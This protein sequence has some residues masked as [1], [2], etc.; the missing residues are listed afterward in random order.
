[1][2]DTKRRFWHRK[3]NPNP[4]VTASPQLI[5]V[6][7]LFDGTAG[8]YASIYRK[9]A[10]VR[11]VV[12]FL[13]DAVSSTS[14]KV[15]NRGAK[16][17]PEARNHPYSRLLRSP[18]PEMTQKR[19]ISDVVHDL[20]LYANAYWWKME[21]GGTRWVVPIPPVRVV[22]RGG[23]L[24]S[25]SGYD[26]YGFERPEPV[27]IPREEMVHFRLYDPEDRRI[28]DSKLNA[29]RTILSEE[30]E[31]SK[32]RSGFWANAARRDGIIEMEKDAPVLSDEARKRFREDWQN[33][34]AGAMNAG[35]TV[36]LEG[37]MHWNADSFSPKDSAF[38]EGRLFVLEATARVFNVP[39]PLLGLTETATY[40][41]QK[42]F[43]KALYQDTLPPWYE[44]IQSELDLQLKPW[45]TDD[46]DIYTEFDPDSK[47]WGD[48]IERA[49]VL[50]QTIGRPYMTVEEG[51]ALENLPDR[52]DGTDAELAIPVNNIQLGSTPPPPP[53]LPAPQLQA[54]SLAVEAFRERQYRSVKSRLGAGGDFDRQRWNR[55]LTAVL[56]TQ[57][58]PHPELVADGLNAQLEGEIEEFGVD[59]AFHPRP[60]LEGVT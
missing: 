26:V 17:R 54:A 39:L 24:L 42:E 13:A 51:R 22:P 60:A 2:S 28:G 29:L 49:G 23:N 27:R 33:A 25:V 34:H 45:F 57:G 15:Y 16:G 35:K 5:E 46:E 32:N 40:A 4:T 11:T 58:V 38:L 10:P 47:L 56:A 12:D 55:E 19:L 1:V 8:S 21:R 37:G 43:H 6:L 44:T 20:A 31:A 3:S 50:I 53:E 52:G 59:Q 41:S 30:V 48:P 7:R 36:L 14:L 9:L 18:N